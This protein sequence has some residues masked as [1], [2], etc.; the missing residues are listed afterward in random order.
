MNEDMLAVRLTRDGLVEQRVARPTPDY[1][2]ILIRVGAAG[3]CHSDAHYRDGTAPPPALP[4]TLGHEVAGRVEILGEGVVGFEVGDRVALHY[5]I[6]CGN[7]RYCIAGSEQFCSSG[8]M[9]GKSVDGGYAE[10]IVV[11]ARNCVV[12]PD[13]VPLEWGAVMMC[14][15]A[16]SYHAIRKARFKFGESV[17][18][19]GVGGLGLSAIQ[20]LSNSGA[21]KVFAVDLSKERL[22][23][24]Q[25]Y[26]AL[27][28]DAGKVDPIE[29]ILEATNGLGVDVSL[30]LLGKRVTIEQSIGCLSPMGRAAIVGITR[31]S[32]E[33]DTYATLIGSERELIGVSDHLRSELDFLVDLAAAG[34]L[35]YSRIVTERIPLNAE[36]INASLDRLAKYGAG[37]RTVIDPEM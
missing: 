29:T 33:L 20:L 3:I 30:E 21:S 14:S 31:E 2:E 5:L 8:G 28:I 12:L 26:G 22:A 9:I 37:I 11:P 15:T 35:N 7:C 16:T 36:S 10:F 32:I 1:G 27:P 23:L 25:S 6:T 18:L 24:V 17:A 4:V 13:A 19:F 34:K